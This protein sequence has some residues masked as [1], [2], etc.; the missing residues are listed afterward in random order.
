MLARRFTHA[1]RGR[2]VLILAL[3][4]IA[5]RPA[6]AQR[7]PNA[8]TAIIVSAIARNRDIVATLHDYQYQ[9]ADRLLV[10]DLDVSPDSASSLALIRESRRSVSWQSPDRYHEVITARR[11][12]NHLTPVWSTIAVADIGNFQQDRIEIP[13]LSFVSPIA[14]GSLKFY[15]F[16]ML[17][18][19]LVDGRRAFRLDV[20]P[21]TVAAPTVS[22]IIIIADSSYDVIAMDL[23]IHDAPPFGLWKSLRY[24]ERFGDVG[25]GQWLPIEIRLSGEARLPVRIPRTPQHLAFEQEARFTEFRFVAG[26]HS[27]DMREVRVTVAD[28]ADHAGEAAWRTPSP[29]PVTGAERLTWDHVDSMARRRSAVTNRVQQA[30]ILGRWISTAPDF[31]HFNRVDGAYI[32]IGSTWRQVPALVVSGKVGYGTASDRWQYRIGGDV[33]ASEAHRIWFGASYHDETISRPSLTGRISDRTIQALLYRRD[34]LDYYGERGL[35]LSL[36]IRPFDF[37]RLELHY[38]DQLQRNLPAL[39]DYSLLPTNRPA[40]ANGFIVAGR[41]RTL[42]GAFSYDSRSLLR[43]N[44]TDSRLASLTWTR[45]MVSGEVAA[46]GLIPNDFNFGRFVLQVERHQRTFGLGITT[47]TA[48]AGIGIGTVPPQRYFTIEA[49]VRALGFQGGGFRTLGD[50]SFAGNRVAMLSVRHD[51]DRLLFAE[52]GLPLIRRLP[53]TLSVYG[54]LFGIGFAYHDRYPGDS[55]FHTTAS[56]YSE[57]GFALGN[58]L[59]FLAP[60]NVGAQFTWQLSAQSTQRFQFGLDL[61]GP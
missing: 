27:G 59:P 29:I 46:P 3:A 61:R 43:R 44:G 4:L 18:T 15:R 25:D 1:P 6:A 52:S 41:M 35:T 56:P 39:T 55:A 13:P 11:S 28:D 23:A 37:T 57:A 12:S 58:L 32:G 34:P 19:I 38:D 30:S 8:G 48:L 53:F 21:R 31:F 14:K 36:A 7:V 22:G 16:R 24:R 54:A 60:L 10:R 51:F 26:D 9:L 20:G 47:I 40:R 49:G 33:R 45:I 17:D 50:T 2:I 42:S 5:F